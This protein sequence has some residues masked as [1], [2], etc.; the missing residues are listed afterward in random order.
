MNR[1]WC[2]LC[3]LILLSL[4]LL[5]FL[6]CGR[7]QQLVSI[8][9]HPATATFLTPNPAAQIQYSAIGTFMHPPETKDITSQVTWSTDIPQLITIN[10][11]LVSPAGGCGIADISASARQGIL[12]NANIVIGYATVTVNDPTDSICPGGSTS[13]SVLTVALAGAGTGSVVSSPGGIN[14]PGT[15]C[16]A[17]FSTGSAVT[18]TA[19]PS[20]GSTFGSWSSNCSPTSANSCSVV[21]S[22]NVTVTATF[23]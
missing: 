6:S 16:G 2:S 1:N 10:G 4:W 17:Q 22:T 19:T 11:G 3:G 13:Q 5:A 14:C 12:S 9:V 21:V 15:A 18:L 20:S 8:T 23:N 7:D